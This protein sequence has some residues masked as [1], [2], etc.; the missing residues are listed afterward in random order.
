MS[1]YISSAGATYVE[2]KGSWSDFFK[3]GLLMF[4]SGGQPGNA[5]AAATGVACV[6]FTD[7]ALAPTKE[8]LG[9][10]LIDFTSTTGNVT[11]LTIGGVGIIGGAAVTY[12][13]PS[14][15]ATAVAAR[16]NSTRSVVQY[17]AV[18][19][20]N[21]VTITAPKNS[22]D[23]LN[24]LTVACTVA[25]GTCAINGGSSTTLGGTGSTAGVPAANCLDLVFPPTDGSCAKESA[26]WQGIA[27]SGTGAGYI[28]FTNSFTAG[29]QTVGWFRWYGSM[30]DP[31]LTG[32]PTADTSKIYL[33]YDGA[34]GTDITASGGTVVSF[35]STQTQN[36]W[37]HATTTSQG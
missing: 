21:T 5:D 10:C 27:G 36:S 7:T 29:N 25:A 24:G 18:A 9:T 1:K 28:G 4:Y 37:T 31:E 34:I 15:L 17:S 12:A 32:T 14:A 35:G 16:I 19:A 11:A 8:V 33:R 3:N 30:D 6:R 2:G 20:T 23:K 13:S 26:V 22:G